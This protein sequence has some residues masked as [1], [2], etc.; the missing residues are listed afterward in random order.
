[1][2]R[3]IKFKNDTYLSSDSIVYGRNTLSYFIARRFATKLDFTIS[4]SQTKT[5]YIGNGWHTLLFIN[6]HCYKRAIALISIL[7]SNKIFRVDTIFQSENGA[8]PEFSFD[9]ETF[10][11]TVKSQGINYQLRG[12][13]YSINASH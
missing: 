5:I 8:L 11:L 3:S 13:L 10:I 9:H 7:P 4:E 2:A 12:N 1:M 6:A